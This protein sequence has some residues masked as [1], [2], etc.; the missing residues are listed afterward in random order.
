MNFF[1]LN[2]DSFKIRRRPVPKQKTK[3]VVRQTAAGLLRES[4][5]YAKAEERSAKELDRLM[6]GAR[7]LT[8]YS[9]YIDQVNQE[10]RQAD[11]MRKQENLLKAKDRESIELLSAESWARK[12]ILGVLHSCA[13]REIA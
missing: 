4:A 13:E 2:P 11:E 5:M 9:E 10:K 3:P 8:E 1:E 7:D 6:S 12:L